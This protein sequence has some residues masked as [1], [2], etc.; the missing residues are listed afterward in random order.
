MADK[1]TAEYETE[2][3]ADVDALELEHAQLDTALREAGYETGTVLERVTRL[4]DARGATRECCW[5]RVGADRC[6]YCEAALEGA[7]VGA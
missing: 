7:A 2:I 6:G 1:S 3:L 5:S 4:L